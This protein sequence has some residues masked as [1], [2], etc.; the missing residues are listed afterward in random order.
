MT[1]VKSPAC[2][3]CRSFIDDPTLL[4]REIGGLN[5]LSSAHGSVRAD[6]GWCRHHDRFRVSRDQCEDFHM[7]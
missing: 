3:N 2:G 7:A 6:T 1:E 5:I 4:E